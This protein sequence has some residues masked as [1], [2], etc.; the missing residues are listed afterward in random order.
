M[1]VGLGWIG[2]RCATDGGRW[3]GAVPAGATAI[4]GRADTAGATFGLDFSSGVRAGGTLSET[5]GAAV[6]ARGGGA[7][8]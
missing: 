1:M 7:G 4:T 3:P 8:G 6:E 2:F 5:S